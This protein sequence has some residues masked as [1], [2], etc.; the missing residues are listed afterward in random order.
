MIRKIAAVALFAALVLPTGYAA[1]AD[2]AAALPGNDTSSPARGPS[3]FQGVWV[4]SWPSFR[5]AGV[6]QDVTLKIGRRDGDGGFFVLYSWGF[7]PPGTGFPPAGSLK[8]RGREEGDQFIIKWKDRMGRD[9]Q[10][11]LKKLEDNKVKA[12]IDKAGPLEANE[13]P[14]I[15]TYL[16]RK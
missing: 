13:R 3:Y 5:A 12:R 2:N 6:S 11:T 4:G 16:N 1:G 10:I 8:A 15:E 14:F 9:T 7:A